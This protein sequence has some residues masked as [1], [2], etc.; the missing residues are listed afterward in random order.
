M[1]YDPDIAAAAPMRRAAPRRKPVS[2]L[3]FGLNY[4]PELIGIGPYTTGLAEEMAQ[5]GHC[6]RVVAGQPYYPRWRVERQ[7]DGAWETSERR[8]VEV[9]HCPLYVPNRPNAVRR[10]RHYASFA[11]GAFVPMMRAI[12]RERPDAVFAVAP[13]LAAFPV[14]WIAARLRGASLWLHIQDFEVDM[15]FATGLLHYRK[16]LGRMARAFERFMIGRADVVSSISPKMCERLVKMGL[17]QD[18]VVELR[19]WANH[20]AAIERADGSRLRREWRLEGK[21]VALYSGNIGAKQGLELVVEAARAL[22]DRTDIVIL[23]CG[24]GPN[25]SALKQKAHGLANIIFKPL[26]SP[27]GFAE[28]MAM[29]DIHLLPQ[30][31][32][33]ADLVL[34]SKLPNILASG[35]PVVATAAAGTGLASETLGCGLVVPPGRAGAIADAVRRLADDPE[36]SE[37]LGAEGKRRAGLRWSLGHVAERFEKRLLREARRRDQASVSASSA[38]IPAQ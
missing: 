12:K 26:Q 27:A 24:E 6:V 28:M 3:V 35:R 15:A 17:P 37:A 18:R 29:A 20:A 23:V 8:G 10:L 13:S 38:A 33:A 22:Q 36:L 19:N 21:T 32:D 25:R 5:R 2:L 7:L 14:A 34:P 11:A 9:T 30:V 4:T 1:L 16:P 31:A